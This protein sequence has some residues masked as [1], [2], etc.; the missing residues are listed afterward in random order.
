METEVAKQ[1]LVAQGGG[2]E[3]RFPP[4]LRYFL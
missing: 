2:E 3:S 1:E 4:G